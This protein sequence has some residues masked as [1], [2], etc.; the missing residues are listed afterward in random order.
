MASF[1]LDFR[2]SLLFFFRESSLVGVYYDVSILSFPR[3]GKRACPFDVPTVDPLSGS[4]LLGEGG[5]F[6]FGSVSS[7]F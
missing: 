4:P 3:I 1:L 2:P 5:P 7:P 6:S